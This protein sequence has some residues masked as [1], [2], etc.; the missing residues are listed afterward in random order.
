MT[1][2]EAIAYMIEEVEK[3]EYDRL[4]ENFAIDAT[5]QK[6]IPVDAILKVLKGVE[7]DNENQ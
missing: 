1:K 2:E 4:A 7:L 6:K 5:K 3:I